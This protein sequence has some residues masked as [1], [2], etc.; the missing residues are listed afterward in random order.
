[1]ELGG[2]AFC[3]R[4]TEVKIV[5]LGRERAVRLRFMAA[6]LLLLFLLCGCSGNDESSSKDQANPAAKASRTIHL[7]GGDWGLPTPFTF[8]PRGPGYI[9]L[10][11]IYDT[12]IWKDE[13]E[14]IPWLAERWESSPDGLQWTFYLR[15][16]VKWQDGKP[17]TARDVC[18]TFDYLRAHPVE[19]FDLQG[20]S[21]VQAV[22]DE[23]LVF[24]LKQPYAPFLSRV[25]GNVPIIPEHLWKDVADPRAISNLG[26]LVGSGP[27]RLTRYDKAQGAY[28]YEANPHFFL[29]APHIKS[30]FF[31]PVGDPV[32]A[33]ER[34]L[35]DEASIPA[36]LLERFHNRP[37]FSV[38]SGPSY[39]VLTLRFN[40]DQHPFSQPAVR[41][42][43]ARAI[44]CEAL[45]RQ[46][47]PGG[48]QG[49]KPGSPGFLPPDSTWFDAK[50]QGLY[51]YNPAKAK[52][53]L[54]TAGVEDRDGDQVC[55]GA[56][57]ARMQFTLLTT[58]QY[59]RE[60]EALQLMLQKVGLVLQPKAMDVKSLDALVRE[61]RFDLALTGHG[62][63]GAD[64]A[65]IMGFGA[66]ANRSQSFGTP[67][68]PA[69]RT[70]AE[71][72]LASS[73]RSER[74][75]L[76]RSMQRLYAEQLPTLPLYYPIWF[77]AHRSQ[78][79][80][81]WFYTAQGGVG[82]GIPLPYNKLIFIRGN[83]P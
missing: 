48:L 39:W 44:D 18:F 32:A 52:S 51:P 33:L 6:A 28:A 16:G 83:E 56:D 24:R 60:A 42:A 9:H 22:D 10:S 57:G 40:F 25:A 15:S 67:S 26:G 41:Q 21:T 49:A 27:Y 45:I 20:I 76:C 58:P 62:G 23:T 66:A 2:R 29:G 61:G 1:M 31:V 7:P 54:Q 47:V 36:S 14:V 79:L 35:V 73:C 70:L 65:M 63:L 68:L 12:L 78:A 74:L 82:I 4:E 69:Y 3:I 80:G 55:E 75:E 43:L 59:L 13:K 30:I 8:Y 81:G 71:K 34:G 72:L 17:L 38:L 64:P 50:L 53:L 37:D 11:F 77:S 19:W 5:R 46:A